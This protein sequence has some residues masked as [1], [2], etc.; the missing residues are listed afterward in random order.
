[1]SFVGVDGTKAGWVGIELDDGR[2]TTSYLLRPIE[3]DFREL[4]HA[5]VIGIDVPIGF[6]PRK[7]DK[8][9]R[10]LLR[11]A[12]STVFT[13]PGRE[14][15]EASSDQA[16]ESRRSRTLSGGASFTLRSWRHPIRASTRF[17]RRSRSA[18]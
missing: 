1:M 10:A 2:F 3:T 13:T 11:G 7:A 9:A 4:A 18:R 12:A 8:E 15:L 16:L 17:I 5:H 14:L 6:G